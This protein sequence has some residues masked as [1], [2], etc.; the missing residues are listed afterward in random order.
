MFERESRHHLRRTGLLA[1]IR[2]MTTQRSAHEEVNKLKNAVLV[3]Q[4]GV[5]VRDEDEVGGKY[6]RASVH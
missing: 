2:R 6:A 4:M 1:T 3:P 5:G